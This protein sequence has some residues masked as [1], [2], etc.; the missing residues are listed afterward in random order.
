MK[1]LILKMPFIKKAIEEKAQELQL[2]NLGII[3]RLEHQKLH[4]VDELAKQAL[5]ELLGNVNY[6]SI[7]TYDK[8]NRSIVVGGIKLE[9]SQILNLKSEAEFFK[10]SE[11]YKIL[12]ETKRDLAYKT[13]FEKS[14]TF[15]DMRQGKSM[16]YDIAM[17]RNIINILASY[18][19]VARK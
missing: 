18:Q 7:I 11:L 17:D 2:P 4:E 15:E 14:L 9:E 6:K 19:P 16:L 12:S 13:M 3:K 5:Q 1:E 10:A 8:A